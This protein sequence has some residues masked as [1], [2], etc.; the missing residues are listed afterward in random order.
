MEIVILPKSRIF[1]VSSRF[2]LSHK[3]GDVV[4]AKRVAVCGA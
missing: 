1:I 3:G 2:I 4:V